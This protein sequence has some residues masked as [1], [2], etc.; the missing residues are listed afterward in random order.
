VFEKIKAIN[1]E[2]GEDWKFSNYYY[3]FGD[4]YHHTGNHKKEAKKFENGLKIFP[5]NWWLLFFQTRCA[6]SQQGDGSKA[7]KS[8]RNLIEV[9]KEQ[10]HSPKQ[11]E[12]ELGELYLQANSLDKAEEHFRNAL[13][14]NPLNSEV[15]SSLASFLINSDRNVDEGMKLIKTA[16]EISPANETLLWAQGL[17]YYKEGKYEEALSL[18]KAAKDSTLFVHPTLDRQIQ[19]VKNALPRQK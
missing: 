5:D 16:L 11:I 17:G 12:V 1:S 4:V 2:W 6:I 7:T 18:L 9:A 8:V 3:Y 19:N 14:L 13:Q 10:G 15:M